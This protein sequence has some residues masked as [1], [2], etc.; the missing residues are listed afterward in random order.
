MSSTKQTTQE[1]LAATVDL[2]AE[3]RATLERMHSERGDQLLR[4]DSEAVAANRA[5]QSRR[6]VRRSGCRTP[7]WI[8]WRMPSWRNWSPLALWTRAPLA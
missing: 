4:Q 6:C 7:A 3:T 2:I 5:A 8:I 1:R